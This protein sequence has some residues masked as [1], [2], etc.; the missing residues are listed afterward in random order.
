MVLLGPHAPFMIACNMRG[1]ENF[2]VDHILNPD[3][4]KFLLNYLKDWFV[5]SMKMWAKY[6]DPHGF[7]I[8]DDLGTQDSPF[9]SP[10]MFKEFYEPVYSPLFETAHDLGCEFHLHS[11]GKV[12]RLI[13]HFIDWKLDALEF[14]SP[15]MSGY[16]DLKPFRGKIMFWACVNIQ[17]IYTQGTPEECEREVWHMMRNLGTK[18]GGFGAYFYAQPEHIKAPSKNIRAFARGLKKYGNYSK[19][20]PEWWDYPTVEKWEDNIVPPL[21]PLEV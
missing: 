6:G 1:F 17:T 15:R 3:K 10:Q 12:D 8:A 14:D 4:V 11:C 2:M 7:I 13:P 16:T 19:I 9:M 18:N 21:P 5:K 20:P